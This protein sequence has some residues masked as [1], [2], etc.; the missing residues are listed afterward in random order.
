M[1]EL[2]FYYG[3]D[4]ILI[5]VNDHKVTFVNSSFGAFE[6]TI[7]GLKLSQSGVIKEHPDL[8]GNPNWREEAIARFK[9]VLHAFTTE[10]AIAN[11]IVE[12]LKKYGY[13]PKWRQK[14]G[15]RKEKI[16]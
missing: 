8:K 1:I 10:E 5:R 4:I 14:Q 7:E 16:S 9:E 13:I 6:T 3:Q 2:I 15:F 12:D 11:Y